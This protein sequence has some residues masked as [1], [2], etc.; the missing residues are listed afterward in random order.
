MQGFEVACGVVFGVACLQLVQLSF[1][2]LAFAFVLLPVLHH[3]PWENP[4]VQR[5]IYVP[6][7]FILG[8]LLIGGLGLLG[9]QPVFFGYGFHF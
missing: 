3:V 6:F 2:G 5:L 4:L 9:L 1:L 7:L 8:G